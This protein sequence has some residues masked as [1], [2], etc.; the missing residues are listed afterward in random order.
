MTEYKTIKQE[1]DSPDVENNL[2]MEADSDLNHLATQGWSVDNMFHQPWFDKQ[3]GLY[4]RRY[5]T[6]KRETLV[7]T[8]ALALRP[9]L[10]T[11]AWGIKWD[12]LLQEWWRVKT[13]VERE[14]NDLDWQRKCLIAYNALL[15]HT[16]YMEQGVPQSIVDAYEGYLKANDDDTVSMDEFRDVR[17]A[18]IDAVGD[19]VNAQIE[20]QS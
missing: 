2:E 12:D 5:V 19:A 11:K 14:P 8:H 20:V 4:M 10:T 3:G 13:M 7:Q 1:I 6:L 17:M 18:L 15:A 16:A 9:P